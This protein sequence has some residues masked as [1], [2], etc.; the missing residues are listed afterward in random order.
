MHKLSLNITAEIGKIFIILMDES[1]NAFSVESVWLL[2][3]RI[4][5]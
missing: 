3:G 2:V 5:S 1:L 4:E